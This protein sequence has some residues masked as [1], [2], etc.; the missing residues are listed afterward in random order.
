VRDGR[1]GNGTPA[2]Q[3]Q[4]KQGEPMPIRSLPPPPAAIKTVEEPTMPLATEQFY[5]PALEPHVYYEETQVI[6]MIR[7]QPGLDPYFNA[8]FKM[9]SEFPP[10]QRPTGRLMSLG[11]TRSALLLGWSSDSR[12]DWR[13]LT[14]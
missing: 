6:R 9:P 13:R 4:K 2:Y 12:G 11:V 10:A 3:E 8:L 5:N 7:G 1:Q 14:R